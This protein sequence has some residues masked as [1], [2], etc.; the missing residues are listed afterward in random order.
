V[1]LGQRR[2]GESQSTMP[3]ITRR[4][5]IAARGRVLVRRILYRGLILI[6]GDRVPHTIPAH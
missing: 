1:S 2:D 6:D 3:L 5:G 4:R